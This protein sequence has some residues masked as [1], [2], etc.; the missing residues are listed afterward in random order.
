MAGQFSV[1][2]SSDS[3]EYML[4]E[5]DPDH[6]KPVMLKPNRISPWINPDMLKLG[7]RIGRGPFGDVW[8]ASHHH[9]SE[10]YD[11]FHEVAV[12]MLYPI[13]DDFI[14]V[15][16]SKF[17]DI[18][19]KCQGLENVCLLHGISILNGRVCIVMKFH[20]GSIGDM[21]A[22]AKGGKLSLPNVLRYGVELAQGISEL[23]S[24]GILVLNL[25]PCNFLLDGNDHAI[26][27]EFGIPFL[28]IGISLPSLD[29][30]RRP[31]IPHYLAPE[32]WQPSIRGPVS[33][34]T[35]S[36]GLGCSIVEMLSGY[37]PWQ[38]KSADETYNLVVKKQVKPNIPSGLPP[39]IKNVLY[40]CFEYD[41]RNRPLMT[42]ILGV[43]KRCRDVY[44]DEIWNDST[45]TLSNK[46][47]YS[48]YTDWFLSKDILQ[49]GDIVRSR[50]PKNSC[51]QANMA[52]SEG[53]VVGIETKGDRN[54]FILVRVHRFHNPLRVHTSMVERVTHGF[55]S[56]DWVRISSKEDMKHSPIGILHKIYRNGRVAVAF[57][58]M[59]TLWE[60]DYTE[61]Q[62]AASYCIGQFIR[63]KSNIS[64]PRFDWPKNKGG[65]WA[66][67]R[68]MQILPNGCLVLRFPGRLS[69]GEAPDFLA[70]PSEV[71]VVSFANCDGVVKKYQ[72]LEDYHWAV[73]PLVIALGLLTALKLGIFVGRRVRSRPGM[74]KDVKVLHGESPWR[75]QEKKIQDGQ[76]GSNSAWF[77]SSV[78]NMLFGEPVPPSR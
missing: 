12:K 51:Q 28:L 53:I 30:V 47:C 74:K 39:E 78:A 62:M 49:V 7:H 45:K 67:G 65:I 23:H 33:F 46:S 37:Q 57:T 20:E 75:Q 13:K 4:F 54:G 48:S 36:W 19:S 31:G 60:G 63:I 18:F 16:I 32:Q 40:G 77:P 11:R 76:N 70:D 8:L 17:E 55:A 73:R 24:R 66:T 6:L 69:F 71:E 42:D 3:F 52:I 15:F 68:I 41:L 64:N 26:I 59:E 22:L 9:C 10:D 44:K 35:D 25:K 27:G 56:G 61:L 34:E 21:I 5:G 43:F 50:K 29:L 58:G 2:E 72:H 1:S 38:G 14:Q